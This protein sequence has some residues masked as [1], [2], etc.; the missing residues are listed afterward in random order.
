MTKEGD[1]KGPGPY[2]NV[3]GAVG[4][5]RDRVSSSS[6]HIWVPRKPLNS[7]ILR[8]VYGQDG[9]GLSV[10]QAAKALGVSNSHLW[11]SLKRARIPRRR[12][13]RPPGRRQK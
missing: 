6:C 13:G 1:D 9:F 4:V 11:R 3:A 10:R 8:G 5:D 2:R 12:P 7:V